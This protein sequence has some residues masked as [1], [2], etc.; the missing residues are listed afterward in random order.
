MTAL[1]LLNAWIAWFS[2][3][4]C[5]FIYVGDL[6]KLASPTP[7][8]DEAAAALNGEATDLG[9][10]AFFYSALVPL[11]SNLTIPAFVSE[12]AGAGQGRNN[13]SSWSDHVSRVPRRMQMHLATV[14]AVS[15]LVFAGCIFGALLIV[16]ED[17]DSDTERSLK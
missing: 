3:L 16:R 1:K 15:H 14:W 7:T 9:L 5:T 8:S 6:Y 11:L 13:G 4:F 2:V 10:R 12:A 17:I